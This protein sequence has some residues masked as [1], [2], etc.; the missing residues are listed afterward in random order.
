MFTSLK[1]SAKSKVTEEA[2]SPIIDP[3]TLKLMW[4]QARMLAEAEQHQSS[5]TWIPSDKHKKVYFRRSNQHHAMEW[6]AYAEDL[7]RGFLP[8]IDNPL[9]Y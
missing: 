6:R 2:P 7:H 4:E 3:D 1:G 9:K 5:D 8:N